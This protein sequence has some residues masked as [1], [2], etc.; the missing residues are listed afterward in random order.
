MISSYL[1]H[2]G[3]SENT[4]DALRF[5]GDART[6]NNKVCSDVIIEVQIV[7]SYLLE[8]YHYMV[9]KNLGYYM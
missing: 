2:T 9:L 1:L 7:S 8:S 6:L 4:K 5:Y 3:Y